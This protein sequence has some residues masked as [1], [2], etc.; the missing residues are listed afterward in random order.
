MKPPSIT[1]PSPRQSAAPAKP[2]T[3]RL[4]TSL[5]TRQT[6]QPIVILLPC[7]AS[8]RT[9]SDN[10]IILIKI[11]AP[12]APSMP[13]VAAPLHFPNGL[14]DLPEVSDMV[15][16]DVV[17]AALWLGSESVRLVESWDGMGCGGI[18]GGTS[19]SSGRSC[20]L[21]VGDLLDCCLSL[22]P[23]LMSVWVV[24]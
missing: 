13:A 17:G 7:N 19:R 9:V 4:K 2:P 18:H 22:I 8:P 23:F 21:W 11:N 12:I 10:L 24:F 3:Q 14:W 16:Q 5:S 6:P 1:P 20:R 15:A